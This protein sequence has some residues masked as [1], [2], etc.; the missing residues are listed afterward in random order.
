MSD[1]KVSSDGE[2]TYRDM[3]SSLE[4]YLKKSGMTH[5]PAHMKYDEFS[6]DEF[7][8]LDGLPSDPAS[9]S[10]IS[11]ANIAV[12]SIFR[13]VETDG[14]YSVGN[15]SVI[16]SDIH[17]EYRSLKAEA[18]GCTACRL[19]E[20]RNA[21][22]FDAGF[23][24]NPLI[25]FVG[26]GPGADEDRT[27]EPF[28]GKAGQLL[29]AAIT[30]GLGVSRESVYICNVIKCRPPDNRTPLPDEISACSGFLKKQ[31]D[32]VNPRVIVALGGPAAKFFIPSELGIT[33][34]RGS[35]HEWNGK[36]IM[37]TFHPAYILRNPPAKKEFWEDLK[38]VM[39]EVGL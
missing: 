22:V 33:K 38:E 30:K 20:G 5:V 39:K 13:E 27:G 18:A 25:A 14:N 32:L 26:E 9:T 12:P 16:D 15:R 23:V 37:P 29:T 35:W 24:K 2:F 19:Y 34:L 17:E 7:S 21:V 1:E 36:K 31:L 28:V 11:E 3:L 6:E 4:Y 8:V 10:A